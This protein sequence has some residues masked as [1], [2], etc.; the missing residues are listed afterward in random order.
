M[1][2]KTIKAPTR[3]MKPKQVRTSSTAPSDAATVFRRD[4]LT[5][6]RKEGWK[7]LAEAAPRTQPEPHTGTQLAAL[8]A[9][10]RAEY[11]EARKQW[12]ANLTLKTPQLARVHDDIW[13]IVDTN[14]QDGDRVKGAPVIDAF[15]GLGK[16]TAATAFG[17]QL[18]RDRIALVGQRTADGHEHIPVCR[19]GLTANTTMKSLQQ[20]FLEFYGHPRKSGNTDQLSSAAL[21]CV[22]SCDTSLVVIDDV[23][24]L[25]MSRRDGLTVTHHL[26]SLANDFPVTFLF[27][28]VGLRERGLFC[29]GMT[30]ADAA[31]AQT[32][33]RW[34]RLTMEPFEIRTAKGRKEWRTMLLGLER[35]LVLADK[36]PGMLADEL[37]DYL[38][39]R[40]TGHIG[41]LMDLINRGSGRAIRTGEERLT[42]EL[43]DRVKIDEA[44]ENARRE[45]DA[46]MAAG[47]LSSHRAVRS[48]GRKP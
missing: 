9:S 3:T 35:L 17:R 32:G 13:E 25:D 46:A 36:Q 30:A 48:R 26:K 39:A 31:F 27:V 6:A 42:T 44:A 15:P 19:I 16:T 20:G 7:A 2:K 23:H 37:S 8:S 29:E 22:L 34:T 40:T 14:R 4:R 47:R 43:L 45:L 12:H 5:L 1:T 11:D 10:A 21:D 33:R 18:H 28:G 38:F 24:F 41:S